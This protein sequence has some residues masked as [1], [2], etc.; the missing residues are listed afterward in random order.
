VTYI[1]KFNKLMAGCQQY[2]LTDRVEFI[3]Y[4]NE[5]QL[6]VFYQQAAALVYPSLIEGFGIPPLEAMACGVPVIVSDIPIFRE[7]YGDVPIY[8]NLGS[9]DSWALAFKQL[10][11]EPYVAKKIA[12]G[13]KKSQEYSKERM[14]R[15]L[16]HAITALWPNH[17]NA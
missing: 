7:I 4:V 3:D 12:L 13:Q 11:N 5:R 10:A 2:G 8:V 15:E 17:D 9:P 16:F 6:V 14:C 1:A